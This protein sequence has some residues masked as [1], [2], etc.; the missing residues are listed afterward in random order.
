M[1]INNPHYLRESTILQI[2][3]ISAAARCLRALICAEITFYRCES[4]DYNNDVM[5]LPTNERERTA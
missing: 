4:Q 2:F 5:R 3:T 1:D